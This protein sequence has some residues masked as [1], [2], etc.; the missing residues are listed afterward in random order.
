MVANEINMDLKGGFAIINKPELTK[1][2]DKFIKTHN[3]ENLNLS[4]NEFINSYA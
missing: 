2:E 1:K 4:L 3:L